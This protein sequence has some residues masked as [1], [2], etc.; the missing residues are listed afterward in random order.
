MCTVCVWAKK[1]QPVFSARNM[2]WAMDMD[3]DLWVIPAGRHHR[4]GPESEANVLEWTSKYGSVV[5]S[6]YGIGTADGLNEAGLAASALWLSESTYGPR[7]ESL[8]LMVISFWCQYYLDNFATVAQ[9]VADFETSPY[10]LQTAEITPGRSTTIHLQISDATGDVAV[11]EV[12]DG[13]FTIHHGPEFTVLT[14][15]PTYDQQLANLKK[16]KGFGG[17]LPLPGTTA[18]VDRFVRASY[19]VGALPT[20]ESADKAAAEILSVVRNA[21]QPYGTVDPE[22]P[23]VAPTIWTTIRDH[24]DLRYYFQASTSPYPVWLDFSKMDVSVG[25]PVKCLKLDGSEEQ[26]GNQSDALVDTDLFDFSVG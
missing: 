26:L 12:I 19:Y 11:L 13:A 8:P 16:Y 25:A 18:P 14:N 4:A 3:T 15:S 2:D 1:G 24:T 6:A 5:A 22:R 20:T 10:Q 9:A 7:D 17:E 23:N 21:A